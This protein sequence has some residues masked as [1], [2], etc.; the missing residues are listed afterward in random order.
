MLLLFDL[1]INGALG[2]YRSLTTIIKQTG[3]SLIYANIKYP[4]ALANIFQTKLFASR[5]GKRA[6]YDDTIKTTLSTVRQHQSQNARSL[7][8]GR[9]SIQLY[10]APNIVR[11]RNMKSNLF[12]IGAKL[13]CSLAIQ[14]CT[15]VFRVCILPNND[16]SFNLELKPLTSHFKNIPPL[17]HRQQQPCGKQYL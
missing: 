5:A 3:R 8:N 16:Y 15:T 7:L 2:L 12:N 1:P 17:I 6:Q 10:M 4:V 9:S 11:Q 14:R 13:G